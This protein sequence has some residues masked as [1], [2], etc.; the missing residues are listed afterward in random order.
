MDEQTSR[1]KLP[2][3]YKGFTMI[4]S[5][6]GMRRTRTWVETKTTNLIPEAPKPAAPAIPITVKIETDPA[7]QT[8]TVVQVQFG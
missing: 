2:K 7:K 8:P 1:P 6:A 5:G 4:S 3:R